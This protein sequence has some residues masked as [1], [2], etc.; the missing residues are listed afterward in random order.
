MTQVHSQIDALQKTIQ[1][2]Q[3]LQGDLEQQ[4][5]FAEI[6][7]GKLGE[8]IY[9][10]NVALKKEKRIIADLKKQQQ[11]YLTQL[12]TQDAALG[13]QI[14]AAYEL[15]SVQQWK[16]LLNQV[17]ASSVGRHLTY[18]HYLSQARLKLIDNIKQIIANL[19]S[20]ILV[21]NQHEAVLQRLVAQKQQQ[22]LLQ[23][24]IF[25]LRQKLLVA[26]GLQTKSKQQ[27][28]DLLITNQQALQRTL[29]KLKSQHIQLQVQ[30]R[31][32]AQLRGKLS[33]PVKGAIASSFGAHIDSGE[34]RLNGVVIK[35]ALGAPVHAIY[36]GKVI[37]AN[38]L[39]GFGLLV[40]INHGNNYMSLYARNRAIFVKVGSVVSA[41]DVIAETGNSGG[42]NKS[43]LYFEVRQNGSPL[44][45]SQWCV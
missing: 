16:V 23:Q 21:S 42:Y 41:G 31:S 2:N 30:G 11:N 39:R 10:F 1:K 25:A 8:Q 19:S 37:F 24:R 12:S 20:S 35:A 4:L 45:P 43:S 44:N 18:Y 22:Q 29:A 9:E 33:W 38:W 27:Q 17:D 34:Q 14:R 28:M 13:Q 7:I 3:H 40:I 36:D 6:K 26:L 15:G 5:K 32:F